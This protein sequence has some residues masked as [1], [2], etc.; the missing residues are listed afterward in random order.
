MDLLHPIFRHRVLFITFIKDWPFLS[1]DH[2]KSRKTTPT[3]KKISYK[4]KENVIE[5]SVHYSNCSHP[6]VLRYEGKILNIQENSEL[7][8]KNV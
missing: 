8:C 2:E 3:F 5:A 7:D 4:K 6:K 1:S